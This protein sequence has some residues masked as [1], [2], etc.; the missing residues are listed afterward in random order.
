M[1][2][3]SSKIVS[4]QVGGCCSHPDS[5]MVTWMMAS[6]VEAKEENVHGRGPGQL[7]DLLQV[8]KKQEEFNPTPSFWLST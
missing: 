4:R 2:E 1:V 5:V 8:G 7:S 3:S 6:E